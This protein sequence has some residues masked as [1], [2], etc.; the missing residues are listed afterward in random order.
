MKT[1]R[2]FSFSFIILLVLANGC[3]RNQGIT[4]LSYTGCDSIRMGLLKPAKQDSIRLASCFMFTGCDS[5]NLG[6]INSLSHSDSIRLSSCLVLSFA[7]SISLFPQLTIMDSLLVWYPFSNNANDSSGHQYNGIIAS[8][9]GVIPT[10]DRFGNANSAYSFS[11]SDLIKIPSP[12]LMPLSGATKFTISFWCQFPNGLDNQTIFSCYA[13][14]YQIYFFMPDRL[15]VFD[16]SNDLAGHMQGLGT[17]WNFITIVYNASNAVDNLS[18]YLN[19]VLNGSYCC[20]SPSFPVVSSNAVFFIGNT[21]IGLPTQVNGNL[22]EFRVYDRILTQ[23]EI[24][25]LAAH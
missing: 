20:L 3:S 23:Q 6:L 4:P 18:F 5:I 22:D 7:D 12:A 25:Y 17:Q 21:T 10:A 1:N 9:V 11:D 13:P 14:E 15:E 24:T 16:G 19:G 8:S 2:I